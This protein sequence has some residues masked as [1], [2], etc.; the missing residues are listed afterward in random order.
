MGKINYSIVNTQTGEHAKT[1]DNG[2]NDAP[3]FDYLA[4]YP[5]HRE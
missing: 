3:E 1:T 2:I 4:V 5:E